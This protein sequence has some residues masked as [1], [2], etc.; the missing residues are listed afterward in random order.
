MRYWASTLPVGAGAVGLHGSTV[1]E[2]SA[3]LQRDSDCPIPKRMPRAGAC[4]FF[5]QAEDGI[6]DADVTGV[7]TCA[8]PISLRPGPSQA[9]VPNSQNRRAPQ[10]RERTWSVPAHP[11]GRSPALPAALRIHP[12]PP[13]TRRPATRSTRPGAIATPQTKLPAQSEFLRRRLAIL[14][15]RTAPRCNSPPPCT[16]AGTLGPPKNPSHGPTRDARSC[17]FLLVEVKS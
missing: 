4:V 14:A 16:R 1:G 10:I 12:A 2:G 17:R 5:F 13:Q 8:L 9:R 7:Q 3:G 15:A 6:R 11:C